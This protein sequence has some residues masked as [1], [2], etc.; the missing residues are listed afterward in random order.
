MNDY[1]DNK[2]VND[3]LDLDYE[4]RDDYCKMIDDVETEVT[5]QF[6]GNC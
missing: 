2:H 5:L 1:D 3:N 6:M 4:E